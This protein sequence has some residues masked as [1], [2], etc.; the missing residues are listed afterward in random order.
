MSVVG[1][2]TSA[3]VSVGGTTLETCSGAENERERGQLRRVEFLCSSF[4]DSRLH[5]SARGRHVASR[6]R[7]KGREV[8]SVVVDSFDDWEEMRENARN[9]LR[10][11][12]KLRRRDSLSI[13]PLLGQLRTG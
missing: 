2:T 7:V 13:S 4:Q 11:F 1:S 9:Q 12:R 10:L 8:V 5:H 6:T 3:V